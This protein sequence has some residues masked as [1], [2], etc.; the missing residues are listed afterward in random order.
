MKYSTT[1]VI[2]LACVLLFTTCSL[3]FGSSDSTNIQEGYGRITIV[4]AGEEARTIFPSMS[5]FRFTYTFLDKDDIEVPDIVN[6]SN[7]TNR[8]FTL[9]V[10]TNFKV[11]VE[12]FVVVDDNPITVALGLSEPFNV[13]DGT[14]HDPVEIQLTPVID[15]TDPQ[16]G[17]FKYTITFPQDAKAT[18]T[19]KTWPGNDTV[20]GRN[21]A[22]PEELPNQPASRKYGLTDELDDLDPGSYILTVLVEKD[23]KFA[24]VSEAVHI[25]SWTTT[26]YDEHFEDINHS[27]LEPIDEAGVVALLGG[28]DFAEAGTEPGTVTL[29][30]PTAIPDGAV[31]PKDVEILTNGIDL[32]IGNITL[33]GSLNANASPLVINGNVTVSGGGTLKFNDETKLSGSGTIVAEKDSII[34]YSA[35]QPDQLSPELKVTLV[36]QS[37]ATFSIDS[38]NDFDR[39]GELLKE[40][41][42]SWWD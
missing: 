22:D 20:I 11:E 35:V 34:I 13:E 15:D 40:N 27:N 3:P 39:L 31:I 29:I 41:L 17:I 32:T 42:Y 2:A 25:Y 26:I 19:L 14:N 24:G 9:P 16:P 7:T 18:I 5:N 36:I 1:F 37:G 8:T 33:L 12:A 28:E 23:G 4:F 30:N 10:G 6:N 21:K 38:D